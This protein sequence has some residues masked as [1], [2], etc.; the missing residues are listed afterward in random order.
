MLLVDLHKLLWV[1][2]LLFE[3]NKRRHLTDEIVAQADH[4]KFGLLFKFGVVH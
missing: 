2:D 1:V 3:Q 4:V